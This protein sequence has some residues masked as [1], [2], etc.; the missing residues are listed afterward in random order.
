VNINRGIFTFVWEGAG[1]DAK[2]LQEKAGKSI[3]FHW[4]DDDDDCYF[5]FRLEIDDL[6][7]EVAL[8]ITDFVAEDEM[9]ESKQLWDSQVGSLMQLLGS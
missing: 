2:K 9:E 7:S 6:T 8:I 1:Q 5:E 4:V 3:R